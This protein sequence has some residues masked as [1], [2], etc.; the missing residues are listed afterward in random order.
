[1]FAAIS[2]FSWSQEFVSGYY[3]ITAG[4]VYVDVDYDPFQEAMA[5]A[6]AAEAMERG[7]AYY[8]DSYE[9]LVLYPGECIQ[10]IEKFGTDYYLGI[11][12]MGY[13]VVFKGL[14]GLKKITEPGKVGILLQTIELMDKDYVEGSIVWI[15][16]VDPGTQQTTILTTDG[17]TNIP[18]A[19]IEN[20]TKSFSKSIAE[21]EF[22]V[23]K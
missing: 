3:I 19:S 7:E 4:A 13:R 11:Y 16:N 9:K 10:L 1:M 2:T 14:G 22:D 12:G 15:T 5:S 18:T 23:V 6:E 8:G 17:K 20:L 21:M